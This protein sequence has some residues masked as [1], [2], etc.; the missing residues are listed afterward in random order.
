ME[1]IRTK[2]ESLKE[3]KPGIVITDDLIKEYILDNIDLL[4]KEIKDE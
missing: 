4:V 2:I 1:D 3:D